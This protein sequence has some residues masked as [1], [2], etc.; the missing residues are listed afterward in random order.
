MVQKFTAEDVFELL[1]EY[2]D[3]CEKEM[4]NKE[5]WYLALAQNLGQIYAA[6]SQFQDLELQAAVLPVDAHTYDQARHFL[7]KKLNQDVHYCEVMNPIR[8][9]KDGLV[10]M[11]LSDD[12]ADIYN[13]F[14]RALILAKKSPEQGMAQLVSDYRIHRGA[15]L[16]NVLKV[17][18]CLVAR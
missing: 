15:H 7:A 14:Q 16:V 18:Y 12:L 3:Q 17:L 10:N 9:Q 5:Q 13:D 2:V 8:D 6:M 4:S 1:Q 11:S